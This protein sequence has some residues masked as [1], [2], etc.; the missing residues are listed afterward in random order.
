[1]TFL[2]A[3]GPALIWM[4]VTFY[5]SHQSVVSIPMGAPD[6]VAHGV[7]YAGL[8]AMLMRGFAGGRLSA[9]SWRWVLAATLIASLYGVSDEFH[10]SFIPGRLPSLSDIVADTIGA[11]IGASLAAVMGGIL[12]KSHNHDME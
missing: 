11:L 8:G 7:S 3:W 2:W 1:M 5:I 4:A 12:R 10:Q 6:Y 9:M